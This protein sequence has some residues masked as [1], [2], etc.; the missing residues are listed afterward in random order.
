MANLHVIAGASGT[1]LR[2]AI[3][4]IDLA[5]IKD[6]L[7]K[8][9]DDFLTMP[10]HLVFLCLIY[11][12]V[13]ACLAADQCVIPALS[14]RLG[15]CPHRAFRG[16]RP[17]RIEPAARARDGHLLAA[18]FRCLEL[19]RAAFDPGARPL[20]DGDLPVLACDRA[21]ALRLALRPR[22]SAI[23]WA[24]HRGSA[25]DAAWMGTH[26]SGKR[27]RLRLRRAGVE[28]QRH[29]LPAAH[30]PRCRRRRRHSH[31]H[32]RGPRQSGDDGALGP[33]RRGAP[34]ARH[35]PVVHR[36]CRRHADPRPRDLAP[37]PQ[38]CGT[39]PRRQPGHHGADGSR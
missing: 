13:G 18:R 37:L 8:G 31:F 38:G 12:I 22:S 34:R 19:A 21:S 11:P 36:P 14:A 9:I 10:S 7:S 26:R 29:F 25:H 30:R 2:P 17:L 5:D 35:H 33:D 39:R 4:K 15:I 1:W 32:S 3:R 6:A 27:D 28:H 23:L 20:V 24:V 16:D